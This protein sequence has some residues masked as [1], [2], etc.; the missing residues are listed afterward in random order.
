ML[1]GGGGGLSSDPSR[2]K[3]DDAT[4][5]PRGG[6]QLQPIYVQVKKKWRQTVFLEYKIR[7]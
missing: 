2:R 4:P 1:W 7:Y 5:P 3:T 6:A